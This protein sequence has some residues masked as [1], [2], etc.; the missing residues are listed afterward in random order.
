M[1][2]C[3][4]SE[5]VLRTAGQSFTD[6]GTSLTTRAG[7]IADTTGALTAT[8]TGTAAVSYLRTQTAWNT[9]ARD[10]ADSLASVGIALV[11]MADNLVAVEDA[12]KDAW[13]A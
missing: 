4:V 13:P 7:S 8:W 2:E 12:A 5:Q 11:T 1:A 10:E 9:A 3:R 6:R